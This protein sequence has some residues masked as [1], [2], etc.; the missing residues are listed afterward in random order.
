MKQPSA[1][2]LAL[3]AFACFVLMPAS[4]AGQAPTRI[5]IEHA[6]GDSLAP[7]NQKPVALN[8]DSLIT[9]I[10]YPERAR[11]AGIQGTVVIRVL[12]TAQGQ[13]VRHVVTQSAHPLLDEAVEEKISSIRFSPGIQ[14]GR[15]VRC[16]VEIPFQFSLKKERRKKRDRE[17]EE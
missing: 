12:V 9:A 4:L 15:S 3:T 11:N 13:F 8:L 7:Q 1:F 16:W 5:V 17:N 14:N 2:F 6:P 10:G